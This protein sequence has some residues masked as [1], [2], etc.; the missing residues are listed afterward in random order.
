ML[1]Y[2]LAILV[3][4]ISLVLYLNAFIRPKIHRK[5]DFLWSGLGL[6]YALVLW[7]CAGRITGAILLGQVA[8]V[9]VFIAFIWENIRLRA[10]ITAQAESNQ[11]LE[12]FSVL[13]FI[14]QSLIGLSQLGRKKIVSTPTETKTENQET[15]VET[16]ESR[17]NQEEVMSPVNV[18]E[19]IREVKEKIEVIEEKVEES[20]QEKSLDEDKPREITERLQHNQVEN[21]SKAEVSLAMEM[22]E[23]KQRQKEVLEDSKEENRTKVNFLGRISNIFRKNPEKPPLQEQLPESILDEIED[24]EKEI[25]PKTTA[26]EVEEAIA[27]LDITDANR[28]ENKETSTK[29]ATSVD[30]EEEEEVIHQEESSPTAEEEIPKPVE[31]IAEVM[32]GETEPN[33]IEEEVVVAVEVTEEVNDAKEGLETEKE[34]IDN[35]GDMEVNDTLQPAMAISAEEE[36]PVVKEE[37]TPEIDSNKEEEKKIPPEDTIASLDE[38]K[39]NPK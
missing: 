4:I 27:K 10:I 35:S 33:Q 18:K 34:V 39:I 32:T 15:K 16:S 36:T 28:E 26:V 12:G 19:E 38:L 21:T 29:S 5:D 22:G 20:L 3:A 7:I 25:D 11:V 23:E 17:E 9:A 14:A 13:S 37:K 31:A 24:V 30:R 2:F 6:F 1:A 8:G